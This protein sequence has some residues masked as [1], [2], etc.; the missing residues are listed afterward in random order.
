[1]TSPVSRFRLASLAER[2][3]TPLFVYDG[4]V[5]RARVEAVRS[6]TRSWPLRIFYSGKANP[7]VGLVAF[8]RGLGLGFDACS[9]GDL[10]L[11]QLAGVPREAISYTSFGATDDELLH[12]A[13]AAGDLV[14]DSAEEIE[15]VAGLAVRRPIGLRVNPGITAGFHSHVAAGSSGAKFGVAEADVTRAVA[16]AAALGLPVVG[17]HA[18]VGSD[19]LEAGA[20]TKLIAT[21]GHL[22]ESLRGI[23]WIN[24]GGGWGTPRRAADPAFPW[25]AITSAAARHLRPL[26]PSTPELRV[27]PG[28]HLTMDA[29]VL[30]GRVVALKAGDTA[31]PTTLVTDVS[32]NH[33]PSV[34][35]YDAHHAVTIVGS[36]SGDGRSSDRRS[37]GVPRRY[38]IAGNLMQ[39]GDV[40]C[41][42]AEFQ[43]V[44]VGDVLCFSHAGAYAASRSTTFNE[45]PRPAE[46]LIDGS[47]TVLLRR[48]ETLEDLFG[49]DQ[50]APG[51][52]HQRD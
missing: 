17:L 1:M 48:A 27:E 51:G 50:L 41:K 45:R 14:L 25:D 33:L 22:A 30:L 13:A 12:A 38:R 2:Y 31:R 10:R 4:A 37:P 44:A 15:R 9:P 8:I 26:G 21:L 32:T 20:H 43:S 5:V 39:A 23:R 3:G 42:E 11:A 18:H 36:A 49:R 7:A 52:H 16:R 40:L 24:L 6:A 35:L 28:G 34:L 19:V 47:E 46:V 29:G